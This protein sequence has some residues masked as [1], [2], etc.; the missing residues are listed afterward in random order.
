MKS[1]KSNANEAAH[2]AIIGGGAIGCLFADSAHASGNRVTLCVRTPFERVLIEHHGTIRVVPVSVSADPQM[3]EPADWVLVATK[4]H[5]TAGALPW[6]KRLVGPRTIVVLLQNG[7]DSVEAARPLI[8]DAAAIPTLLYTSAERVAPGHIIH[9]SGNRVEVPACG[10]S[11]VFADLLRLGT[12]EIVQ[13]PDFV[14]AAW[15]KLLCNIACNPITALTMQ[16]LGV[17]RTPSISSLARG[18]MQEAATVGR[19]V[20]AKLA[21]GDVEDML[22]VCA[23]FDAGG[24]TSMLYDRLAGHHLEHEHLTGAIVRLARR[25]GIE[26]PLNAAILALLEALD[27]SLRCAPLTA[28]SAA[29]AGERRAG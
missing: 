20:G 10:I 29:M 1:E 25:F 6:L 16:R 27:E 17:L 9:H 13:Q 23:L 22:A 12:I 24:G 15:R 4:T 8:G 21:D 19:A 14:T 2:V 5:D 28:V 11:A 7:V 18:L 3:Q 26:V